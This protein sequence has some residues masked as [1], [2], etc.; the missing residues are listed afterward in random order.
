MTNSDNLDTAAKTLQNGGVVLLPTDTVIGLAALPSQPAAVARIFE[1][2]ARP[3]QKNL[4]V[5]VCSVEQLTDIGAQVSPQTKRLVGSPFCPG[6]LSMA[7]EVLPDSAPNW[8]KGRD[9]LAFRMPD[10]PFLLA[11]LAMVGPMLVTSANQHGADTPSTVGSALKS[12][13]GTPDLVINGQACGAVPSTLVNC[14]FSPPKIE[15]LGGV[16]LAEL[17]PYLTQ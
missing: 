9:E 7:V 15:R 6:P 10:D 4:P 13:S 5:M 8:L 2:K 14:R 1:L 16:T 11:L 3:Q 12:L 17:T